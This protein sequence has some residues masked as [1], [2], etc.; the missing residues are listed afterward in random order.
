M[1][2]PKRLA[3]IAGSLYLL[4]AILGSFAHLGAVT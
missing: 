3:R 4:M 2:T 1:A